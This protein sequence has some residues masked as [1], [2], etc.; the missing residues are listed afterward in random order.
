MDAIME[1]YELVLESVFN[2]FEMIVELISKL[3]MLAMQGVHF[4]LAKLF[5]LYDFVK[6][7]LFPFFRWSTIPYNFVIVRTWLYYVYNK[8]EVKEPLDV[9]GVHYCVSPPGGGKSMLAFQK[10]NE[11]ADETGYASYHTSRIEKPRL[12]KDK[13]FWVV[14]HRV[15]DPKKYYKDRKKIYRFNTDK[16]KAFFFDEFHASNNAR[17]NKESK[18]NDFFIPFLID[19]IYIRHEGF[20]HNIY[21]FSQVPNN[22]IQIMSMITRYHDISMKKGLRYIDWLFRGKFE[23]SPLYFKIKTYKLDRT[24]EN[25]KKKLVRVWKKKIDIE[26]LK[27]FDTHAMAHEFDHLPLDFE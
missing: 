23:I 1:K 25:F 12:S 18:Y 22:D 5:D 16:Y 26:R 24:T 9:P 27:Y 11:I 19:L 13:K 21:L 14:T 15:I 10:S 6:W 4:V 20:D 8:N 2:I 3:T 17:L 7:R